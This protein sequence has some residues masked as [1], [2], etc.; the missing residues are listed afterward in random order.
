[1]GEKTKKLLGRLAEVAV[2][3]SLGRLS[4]SAFL[5]G[6]YRGISCALQTGNG[7]MYTKSL[8]SVARAC[9][10]HFAPG[11]TAPVQEPGLV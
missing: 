10:R 9:G 3:N 8:E 11:C 6:A 5:Q 4:R 7:L 2:N 1:M